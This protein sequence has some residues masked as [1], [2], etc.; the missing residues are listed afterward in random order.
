MKISEIIDAIE[1]IAPL[2]L[3]ENYDNAGIQVGDKSV[4]ASSALLCLDGIE[5][6]RY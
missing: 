6:V 1:T 4:E 3:Q 5:E 2:A